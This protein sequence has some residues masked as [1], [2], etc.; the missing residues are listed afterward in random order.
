MFWRNT[1]RRLSTRNGLPSNEVFAIRETRDGTLLLA[2]RG[3]LVQLRGDQLRTYRPTDE[4]NRLLVVDALEDA[5]GKIWLA[6]PSGLAVLRNSNIDVVVPAEGPLLESWMVSLLQTRDGAV[7][8]GTYGRGLW[9][10][11][12]NRKHLFTTS[13]GLSSDQ[14]RS[15]L[16]DRDGTLWI[17]TFGG[18]LNAL[19]HGHFTSFTIREGLL[20]DNISSIVDDGSSLWLGTT[21]GICRVPK[22]QLRDLADHKT[23]TLQPTN[24]GVEDGLRSGQ[25]APGY[26]VAGGGARTSDGR[27]WF[28]TSRGLAVMDPRPPGIAEPAPAVH[29]VSAMVDGKQVDLRREERLS[30]DIAR[31]QF[32]YTAIHLSAPERVRFFHKLEGLDSDWVAAER[33]REIN[34]N[35]LPHGNYRFL[36]RA[37][38]PGGLASEAAY[39]FE[40]LPHFYETGWFRFLI[41]MAVAA[42]AWGAYRLRMRQVR[43]RFALVLQERAR[44]AREIHDTLA[45]SFVGISSQLEAVAGELPEDESAA[46][47][48]LNLARRMAR[49]SITEARRAVVDLRSSVLE[50]QDLASALQSGIQIWTAGS[51][52]V[53]EVEASGPQAPLPEEVEHN[54][55]RIAQEAVTNAL[56]HSGA[57]KICVKLRVEAQK[58]YLR[59]IDD[60]S[61]FEPQD[62][63][64]SMG[65]HF[66]LIGMRERAERLDG[67]LRLTSQRGKGTEVEVTVLL[68]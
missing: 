66:G 16:E 1:S 39:S 25:I 31:I 65:G 38:L 44:L 37:E 20:S 57:S 5:T 36:V 67:E 33:R 3:G 60:G 51:D 55:L 2:T 19:D 17:G 43:Y 29:L 52:V 8:A 32:H 62:A 63:F 68:P 6:L 64:S 28:P 22:Q 61:G 58:L 49:H 11:Q 42:A 10:V 27:I 24:Y 34:Y 47:R 15:L 54:L 35:S 18:G 9:R 30:P 23:E 12:D 41:A 53:T 7:W 26:P 50:G 4:L 21:R 13:D 45:Q 40:L 46:R 56:K 59:I 48:N 14:I